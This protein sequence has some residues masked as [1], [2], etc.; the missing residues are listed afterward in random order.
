MPTNFMYDES[1]SSSE[2]T[3]PPS[4]TQTSQK[5]GRGKKSTKV[6]TEFDT[7]GLTDTLSK[8][9]A[10]CLD[11]IQSAA[12]NHLAVLK[13]LDAFRSDAIEKLSDYAAYVGDPAVFAATLESKTREKSQKAHDRAQRLLGSVKAPTLPEFTIDVEFIDID[14]LITSPVDLKIAG[15]SVPALPSSE[16]AE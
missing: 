7:K 16:E 15:M 11:A 3:T 9:Q 10:M 13:A 2:M 4:S 1:S 6:P 8:S 5:K 12:D 14:G